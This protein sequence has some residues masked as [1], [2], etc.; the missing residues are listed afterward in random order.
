MLQPA[1]S[2]D[3]HISVTCTL[4]PNLSGTNFWIECAVAESTSTLLFPR[5]IKKVQLNAK[6]EVVDSNALL[7]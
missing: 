1:L 7:N 5:R 3:A 4:N 2:G 6:K